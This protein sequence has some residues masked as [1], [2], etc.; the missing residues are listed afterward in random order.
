MT[1]NRTWRAVGMGLGVL[2]GLAGCATTQLQVAPGFAATA[3]QWPVTGHS[4][5]HW[6]EPVRFGPYSALE[7][8]EGGSFGW[9]LPAGAVDIGGDARDYRY[10]LV[11]IGHPPVQVQCRVS[12]LALGRDAIN[13]RVESRVELDLTSLVAPA[14]GCGLRYDDGEDVSLLELARKGTHLD[15]RLGTPWGEASVRSLHAL[16]GAVVD[17]YSPGGF[18]VALGGTPVMVVDVVNAGRVLFDPA[19]DDGQRAYFA[20]VAAALLLLGP[21]ADA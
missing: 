7:L 6:D 12:N 11:A 21:D 4:P 10:T 8:E 2:L 17:S 19:L 9:W 15:G 20:A 18:E 5:R 13:G 1:T 16:E 3:E 14:L